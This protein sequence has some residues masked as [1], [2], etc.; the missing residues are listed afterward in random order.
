MGR[1]WRFHLGRSVPRWMIAARS[2]VREASP[3]E[4][5]NGRIDEPAP[6]RHPSR[7][8]RADDVEV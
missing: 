3:C 1:Y 2:H 5:G 7:R 4:G 6:I 8:A